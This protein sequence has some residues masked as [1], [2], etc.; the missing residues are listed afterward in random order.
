MRFPTLSIRSRI[1]GAAACMMLFVCGFG[2]FT[3][4]RLETLNGAAETIRGSSLTGAQVAGQL[5]AAAQ[6]YRIAE[7]AYALSTNAMQV[8][9]VEAG[10][11]AVA[12]AVQTLRDQAGP[13]FGS[14]RMADRLAAFDAAWTEYRQVSDRVRSLAREGNSQSAASVFKR[15][16]AVAFVRVQESLSALV[17]SAVTEA[18]EI[19]DHGAAV[20]RQARSLVLLAL[21]LCALGAVASGVLMVRGIS[22]PILRV[23][24]A[25][26][27]LA[28][29]DT[30]VTF[31]DGGRRDEIG[32]MAAAARVFRES[33]L[34]T[35]R[36]QAEQERLKAAAA[37]E[38]RREL[39]RLA[40]SFEATVMALVETLASSTAGMAAA[41]GTMASSASETAEHA[42][43]VSAAAQMA[44]ASADSVAGATV[45]LS[46][47]FAEIGRLVSD[48]ASIARAASGDA[49]RGSQV[50]G[51]LA[52]AAQEIGKVVELISGIASQTNL[53][54]LN[55]TIEAARAGEAG[56][57]FAVVAGEVKQLAAQT[58]KATDEIQA[59]IAEIQS[60]SGT[61]VAAITAVT[62]TIARINEIS[63]QI[64]AAVGQQS[65][66]VDEIASSIT[67]TAAG[68]RD[69]STNIAAVTDAA[70]AARQ[71]SVTMVRS[72]ESVSGEASRMRREVSGFL[73]ALR[74]A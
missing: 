63:A 36:L 2:A 42:D 20:Y 52:A 17:D 30:T 46:A 56:K 71:A 16:S 60:A 3:L 18:G 7:A 72:A 15:P 4:D 66:A 51:G 35:D 61:A 21:A 27:R 43:A 37:E 33:M 28:A 45:E 44:S 13:L 64:S 6:N 69:V 73:D 39:D 54:A 68:T 48:S 55:A 70:A 50:M 19:A 53:L 8:G 29:R 31:D 23:A 5:L 34:E 57:G 74:A 67:H 59:R 25:L 65:A 12:G 47:S 9:Q 58:G 49:E 26:E 1:I 14:G 22:R 32:R 24:G 62:R 10:H 11:A 40:G 41:A 38:R